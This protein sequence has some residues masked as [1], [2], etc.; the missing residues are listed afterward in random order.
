MLAE[1][2]WRPNSG[3][4]HNE[5]VHFSNDNNNS[6]SPLLVAIFTSMARRLLFLLAKKHR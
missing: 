2:L 6:G 1:G 4:E 5:V 3:C